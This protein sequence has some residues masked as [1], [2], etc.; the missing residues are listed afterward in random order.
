MR[1]LL[2]RK[3]AA[4][5]SVQQTA[6]Q[7]ATTSYHW[8]RT[9]QFDPSPWPRKAALTP[10][11]PAQREGRPILARHPQVCSFFRASKF[12]ERF[13]YSR[14]INK[15]VYDMPSFPNNVAQF[16]DLLILKHLGWPLFYPAHTLPH[17]LRTSATQIHTFKFTVKFSCLTLSRNSFISCMFN[18]VVANTAR[19]SKYTRTPSNPEIRKAN[20][21]RNAVG[22]FGIP[23][24]ITLCW[25]SPR[26]YK[27]WNCILSTH[28]Y[29]LDNAF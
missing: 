29:I 11:A 19:S 16:D 2:L 13:G 28:K 3:G 9:D 24:G 23:K 5:A 8:L 7:R 6:N 25:Y 18:R 21:L 12:Y 15:I 20:S 14:K 26:C 4:S 1:Y 17:V 10:L 27:S 22:E